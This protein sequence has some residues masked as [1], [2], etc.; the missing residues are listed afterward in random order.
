MICF[1]HSLFRRFWWLLAVSLLT[2]RLVAGPLPAPPREPT[3]TV[4]ILT[5]TAPEGS[6]TLAVLPDTQYYSQGYPEVFVR[7]TGWIAKNRNALR[8]LFVTHEG[9]ITNNNTPGQWEAARTAMRQLSD[10][11]VPYALAVGNHDLGTR[12]KTDNRETLLNVYFSEK[13]YRNSEAFG[14]FE[15]GKL[16]NSWHRFGTP[17]GPFLLL[18]LEFGPR[19][20][21]IDWANRV[22]AQ[23]RD[24]SVILVTHAYLTGRGERTRNLPD[25][26]QAGNPKNYP[27]ASR[28]SVNDG[29]DLW[30]KLISKHPNVV[31][32]LGGH[33]TG[34]G[35]KAYRVDPGAGGQ[36]VHQIFANYQDSGKDKG[37]VKPPRGFGGGGYLK[38]LRF[39]G[40]RVEVKSYSPWYD[41]WLEEPGQ[42]L[43]LE[44]LSGSH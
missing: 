1:P 38:L 25:K 7:Q 18:A 35:G 40:N 36:K 15:P 22:I 14:L 30:Q 23:H 44:L 6:W 43:E 10:T 19:N 37:T 41:H 27:Y 39:S 34:N 17:T 13:D 5:A 4:P 21:V 31:L 3:A 24:C 8:I 12:G 42:Q 33:F 16:E 9:D 26:K 32:V 11:G 29:E 2:V 20:E 28:E